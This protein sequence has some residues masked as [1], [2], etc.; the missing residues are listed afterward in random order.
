M[1]GLL[2]GNLA[3]LPY[4][5]IYLAMYVRCLLLHVMESYYMRVSLTTCNEKCFCI[6]SPTPEERLRYSKLIPLI[7]IY[8]ELRT[9]EALTLNIALVLLLLLAVPGILE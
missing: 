3:F 1:V 5:A 4:F 7:R 2:V 8:I 9:G 6:T